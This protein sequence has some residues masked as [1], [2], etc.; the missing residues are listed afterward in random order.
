VDVLTSPVGA[1]RLPWG[2]VAR[3]RL[4]LLL[5]AAALAVG[6]I[7]QG[8]YHPP[9]Q[10]TVAVV[11]GLAVLARLLRGPQRVPR[12]AWGLCAGAAGLAAWALV[13]A[14]LA[15]GAG[16]GVPPA[17][18]VLGV[19][20]VVVLTLPAG[21]GQR[22][23]LIAAVLAL[24]VVCA[25]VGWVGVAWHLHPVGLV[26]QQLWRAASTF[27]Y[28]NA[29]A[30]LLAPLALLAVGLRT[31]TATAAGGLGGAVASEV[32]RARA[33]RRLALGVAAF[34][35]LVGLGA[36]LSRGGLVASVAGVCVLAV[37]RRSGA[38]P[39][40]GVSAVVRAGLGPV[41]GAGVALA[42][43]APSFLV[44]AP[45]RPGA[46]AAGLVAGLAAVV[47]ADVW[48]RPALPALAGAA[49]VALAVGVAGG[50]LDGLLSAGTGTRLTLASPHRVSQAGAALDLVAAQPLVGTGPGRAELVW[51]QPDGSMLLARYVHNEYVQ[52]LTELGGLGA[53]LLAV[54]LAGGAWL[55]L[56]GRAS[57]PA[58]LWAGVAA[59]LAALAVHSA[60]DFLWHLGVIPLVA[61]LLVGLVAPEQPA[62]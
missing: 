45:P 32:S 25:L 33:T 22:R 16:A 15:G 9:V 2:A 3:L 47:V 39:A 43:L 60:L 57:A 61:A 58:G 23:L 18:L 13:R 35:L 5:L 11:L 38:G 7:L 37:A 24:G 34:L 17:G 56:R 55:V 59:G 53:V 50:A 1:D 14:A 28:A 19:A 48:P 49:A 40:G 44:D 10:R 6:V 41:L 31:A 20:A 29:S 51:T 26:D 12:A 30:G 8:A 42:G 46:A 62:R 4:D 54:V 52:V 36:T 21:P 27:T